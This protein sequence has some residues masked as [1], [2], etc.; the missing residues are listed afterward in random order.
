MLQLVRRWKKQLAVWE[1]GCHRS[2]ICPRSLER[3]ERE[4]Q[5]R[6]SEQHMPKWLG[7][8]ESCVPKK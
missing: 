7:L 5:C 4:E 6:Q 8:E 1:S 2:A 3:G